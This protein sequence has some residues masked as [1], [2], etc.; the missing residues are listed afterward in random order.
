[1]EHKERLTL[2]TRIALIM[3]AVLLITGAV[4]FFLVESG[5]T[6]KDKPLGEKLLASLFQSTTTRTAGFNT[7]DFS[8]LHPATLLLF[9]GLMLIGA[10]PGGTGGGIK[11]TTFAILILTVISMIKEKSDVETR[12]RIIPRDVVQKSLAITILFTA[13]IFLAT[14][15]IMLA[16]TAIPFIKVLFEVVSAAATVGLST[17]ITASLSD[18]SKFV[19]IIT[20]FLGRIGPLTLV[21][22]MTLQYNRNKL[23]RYPEEKIMVG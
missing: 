5:S 13:I 6:L 2:H 8:S 20:M 12:K 18:T 7:V 22:A 1:M 4:F 21:M 14:L 19:I 11:T 3:T 16:D 23:V 10:S 17:G 15:A 9:M